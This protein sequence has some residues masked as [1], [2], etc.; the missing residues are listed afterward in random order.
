MTNITPI[1]FS[2]QKSN[3]QYSRDCNPIQSVQYA[4]KPNNVVD[5]FTLVSKKL[6]SFRGREV[7][8]LFTQEGLLKLKDHFSILTGREPHLADTI[9]SVKTFFLELN[10]KAKSRGALMNVSWKP[11]EGQPLSIKN[12]QYFIENGASNNKGY[13]YGYGDEFH[14]LITETDLINRGGRTNHGGTLE[15]CRRSMG[16]EF[17]MRDQTKT[18]ITSVI[19]SDGKPSLGATDILDSL[20]SKAFQ[21][22]NP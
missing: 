14:D 9:N 3:R 12:T 7:A 2:S 11:L 8:K 10:E 20:D 22:L 19:M 15:L 21:I 4:A 6:P 13:V 16:A 5:T 1:G 17:D 18:Y